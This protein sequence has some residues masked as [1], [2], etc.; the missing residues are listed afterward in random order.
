MRVC[1]PTAGSGGVDDH[2]GE[3]FG[4]VPT[5]TIFDTDTEDVEVVDNRSEHR[6]GKGLPPDFLADE[7]IDVLVCSGLGKKAIDLLNDHGIEVH[8]GASGEVREAIKEWQ[9]GS[10][11]EADEADACRRGKFGEH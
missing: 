5:Y 3:H 9:S 10:L 8:V 6:G 7:N 2:I 4:R 11:K 1:F